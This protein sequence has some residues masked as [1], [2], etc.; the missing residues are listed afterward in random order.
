MTSTLT[1]TRPPRSADGH[2]LRL[3]PRSS[4]RRPLFAVS[5][6]MLV[7]VSVAVF[8]SLYLRAGH[9]VSVLAVSEHVE[10]GQA[11]TGSDLSVERISLSPGVSAIPAASVGSIVGRRAAVTLEPGSLLVPGDLSRSSS[12][13][14]GY[15]VVGVALKSGQLPAAGV[16]AG[17]TVDIVMT[18]TPGSPYSGS[19]TGASSQQGS[20]PASGPGTILAPAALVSDVAFPSSSSG[21]DA[22]VVSVVVPRALAP[23]IASA[24]AAGEAALVVVASGS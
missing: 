17:E 9:E 21:S 13:P 5:S 11:L 4:R 8:T 14:A 7:A 10:Q 6:A 16:T 24:S 20:T 15:A 22:V 2:E 19:A 3:A 1:R 18:G 12:V 23:I